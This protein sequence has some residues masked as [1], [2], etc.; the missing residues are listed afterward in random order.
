MRMAEPLLRLQHAWSRLPDAR[1][2]VVE[3]LRS[4]E[5]HHLFLYP[6]AGRHAHLGLASLLAWRVARRAP[7]SFSIAV[8]DYGLE[9]LAPEPADWSGLADGSLLSEDGLLEDVLASLNSGELALRRFREIAR[10]AGLVFQGFPGAPKSSR[11]LQA[12]SGLF[13]EVFRQHDA[14]NLLLVQSQVE[15][16]EQELDIGR[17]RATLARLRARTRVEV[18]LERPGPFAFPLM[19][20]RLREQVSTEKLADRVARMVRELEEAA[21]LSV[22]ASP[23]RAA[24]AR[25]SR[26]G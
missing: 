26:S 16:L 14:D 7:A 10:I 19:I 9:L 17:L 25:G 13:Y 23:A 20:E 24:P 5:G 11:Q 1:T 3:R 2:L 6:F 8:N 12:S 21:G 18:T 22:P 15:V 4:R